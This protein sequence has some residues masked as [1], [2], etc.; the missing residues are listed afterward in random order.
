MSDALTCTALTASSLQVCEICMPPSRKRYSG[1]STLDCKSTD[2]PMDPNTKLAPDQGGH[3]QIRGS[4][5]NLW[6]IK[7]IMTGTLPFKFL[8]VSVG[9]NPR[10]KDGWCNILTKLRSILAT[11]KGRQMSMVRFLFIRPLKYW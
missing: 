8:G 9:S 2:T 1:F 3:F 4:W 10:R 6:N 5:N 7:G 11:W